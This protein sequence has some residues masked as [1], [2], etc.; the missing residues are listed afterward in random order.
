[1]TAGQS[2]KT[3]EVEFSTD[4]MRHIFYIS[5]PDDVDVKTFAHAV[6]HYY[7]MPPEWGRKLAIASISEIKHGN[8]LPDYLH[9]DCL[10][11]QEVA[12]PEENEESHRA[13]KKII[14]Q[15]ADDNCVPMAI[16]DDESKKMIVYAT[17][18]LDVAPLPGA[19]SVVRNFSLFGD[20]TGK[21]RTGDK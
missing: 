3:Y 6:F 4:A 16:Y 7:D 8:C 12:M 1:M 13:A 9:V 17:R 10:A 2:G 5:C 11:G 19:V 18:K 15:I 14:R 21:I 20:I